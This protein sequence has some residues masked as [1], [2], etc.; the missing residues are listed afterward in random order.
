MEFWQEMIGW[1]RGC[2][3]WPLLRRGVRSLRPGD[4]LDSVNHG[5]VT[6]GITM[7]F[8]EGTTLQDLM[9]AGTATCA[10][11]MSRCPNGFD[12]VEV[13]H[14]RYQVDTEVRVRFHPLADDEAVVPIFDGRSLV[15]MLERS[16]R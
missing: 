13:K 3:L 14:G 2:P 16:Q 9:A 5:S 12:E 8:V 10:I 1:W 4:S 7:A 6:Y 15:E 11:W